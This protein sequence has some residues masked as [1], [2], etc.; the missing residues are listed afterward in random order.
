MGFV[1]K[2]ACWLLC[3]MVFFIRVHAQ[4][5][6]TENNQQLFTT[7]S[8]SFSSSA[9]QRLSFDSSRL[10]IISDITITGNKHTTPATI[11]REVSFQVDD[12]YPLNIIVDKFYETRKQLMNTGLFRNVVV[13]LKS[14]QGYNVYVNIE[15]EE[16]WYIYPIPFLRPVDKSFH[17]W[18]TKDRSIDRVNYGIRLEHHNFTGRNDKFNLRYMNGFTKE[19]SLQYYG[20]FLDKSMQW[21]ASGG[22]GFGK[23]KE[24]NYITVDN[25]L[26]ALRY[27]DKYL[28]SYFHS[29]VE[30][31]YRP[32]IKT[33]HTFNIEYNYNDIADTIFKLNPHF[34]ANKNILRYLGFTYKMTYF[35]V[36]FIP[37]PTRGFAGEVSI[38]RQ[39]FNDPINLWQLTA[40]GSNTWPV[41]ERSFFNLGAV[42]MIKLPF[43]QPFISRGFLGYDDQYLQ[44]YEYYVIDGV[45]GG[46]AKATFTRQ[47]VNTHISIPSKRIKQLNYIPIKLYAKTFINAGYVMNPDEGANTLDNRLLY[48]G[49]VG[50]DI[51][52]F[53]DFVIKIEWSFN[54]L[55]ENGVYLHRITYF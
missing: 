2:Y 27:D 18:W 17:D 41:G 54:H 1:F 46:Y 35:D 44:G 37:Y 25:K 15:V 9:L 30:I 47:I 32:A 12:H 26:V 38:K 39:G 53:T 49:G 22:F 20:L 40:K 48:S 7:D 28:N 13:S 10:F 14:L 16:K 5:F 42:G 6:G 36:D 11:L 3:P 55:S 34:S 43:H 19:I 51:V 21:S 8:A 33:R 23:L 31:T 45:A 29:F 50:I 4:S 24:L 52:G